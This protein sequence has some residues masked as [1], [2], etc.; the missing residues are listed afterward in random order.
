[1][2]KRFL[3]V[4][5]AI[6]ALVAMPSQ[7]SATCSTGSFYNAYPSGVSSYPVGTLAS[8]NQG[9]PAF[10]NGELFEWPSASNQVLATSSGNELDWMDVTSGELRSKWT[11]SPQYKRSFIDT[12]ATG[13]QFRMVFYAHDWYLT[14]WPFYWVEGARLRV[15]DMKVEARFNMTN[16]E[17]NSASYRGAHL[18]ARYRSEDEFYVASLRTS[19]DIVV[20]HQSPDTGAGCPYTTLD[21]VRMKLPDGSRLANGVSLNTGTWYKLAVRIVT[22]AYGQAEIAVDVN[23][24]QQLTVLDSVAH[25]LDDGGAGVR[26]DF[27]DTWMDDLYW[28]DL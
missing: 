28:T 14:G 7:A 27:I 19:G 5:V 12:G 23:D 11:T 17:N 24:V 26:T 4:C 16:F 2:L 25:R 6:A 8:N 15:A 3:I 13:A 9:W 10:G 21:S 1:M 22:N 20:K 18:F